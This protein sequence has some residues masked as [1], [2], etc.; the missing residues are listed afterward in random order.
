MILFL[1][2]EYYLF[3]LNIIILIYNN[4]LK[5]KIELIINVNYF[6]TYKYKNSIMNIFLNKYKY[7]LF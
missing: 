2:L 7:S 6:M 5:R 1:Y 4:D 3:T